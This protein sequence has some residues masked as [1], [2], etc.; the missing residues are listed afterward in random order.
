MVKESL[1]RAMRRV[2]FDLV[3]FA[4]SGNR[5]L[6]KDADERDAKIIEQARP[7]TMTSNERLMSLIAAVRHVALNKIEGAIA[8]CGVWNGRERELFDFGIVRFKISAFASS[9]S[10]NSPQAG[11]RMFRFAVASV[12]PNRASTL[13]QLRFSNRASTYCFFSLV[14]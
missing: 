11:L 14:G 5:Q 4:D 3:R 8:E 6:P 9:L 1:H 10:S 2:G 12:F 7:Y 13:I